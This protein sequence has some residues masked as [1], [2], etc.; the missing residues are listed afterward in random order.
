MASLEAPRRITELDAVNIMLRNIGETPVVTLGSTAKPTAQKAQEMLAEESIRVQSE[1]YNFSTERELKLEP[2]DEGEIRLPSNTLSFNPTTYSAD[3][4]L[5]EDG[6]KLYDVDNNSFQFD[7]PIYIQ[8]VLAKPFASL[9]QPVRWFIAVSASLRFANSESPGSS[10]M[11]FT[12]KDVEE[13]KSSMDKYDRRLRKGG[14]R[15]HNPHV[16]RIRGNR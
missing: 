2:N 15:K 5:Q 7:G 12:A 14:M 1:G 10:S 16:R 9:P 3:R 11:R 13:A 8:A 6:G 4:N